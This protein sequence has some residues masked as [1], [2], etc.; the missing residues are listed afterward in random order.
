MVN[1]WLQAPNIKGCYPP[2]PKLGSSVVEAVLASSARTMTASE[3]GVALI[4]EARAARIR[5]HIHAILSR[6]LELHRIQLKQAA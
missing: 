4:R 1:E 2:E 6:R 5:A 3:K